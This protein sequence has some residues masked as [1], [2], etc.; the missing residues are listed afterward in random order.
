MAVCHFA[1]QDGT[2]RDRF[3]CQSPNRLGSVPSS[4]SHAYRPAQSIQPRLAHCAVAAYDGGEWHPFDSHFERTQ[5]RTILAPFRAPLRLSLYALIYCWASLRPAAPPTSQAQPLQNQIPNSRSSHP[6]GS[7]ARRLTAESDPDAQPGSDG[8]ERQVRHFCADCHALPDPSAFPKSA[9]M[10]EVRRGYRFYTNSGRTDLT[11]PKLIEVVG[12]FRDR[13][14]D[15]IGLP[16]GAVTQPQSPPRFERQVFEAR[17][18]EAKPAISFLGWVDWDLGKHQVLLSCDMQTGEVGQWLGPQHAEHWHS[19]ARLDHPAHLAPCDLDRD[20]Q[21]DLI[22]ADL[23][24]FAPSDKLKG[25][26]VWLRRTGLEAFEPQTLADGLGRVADVEPGDFDGDGL[27]DLIVAEFG[28]QTAGRILLLRQISDGPARPR[29]E[30]REIDPR[31]GSIHVAPCDLDADGRLDFIALISQEHEVVEAF[32][33]RGA[34]GFERRTLF[35]AGEPSWGSSGVQVVDLDGDGDQ[36]VVCTNGDTFDSFHLKTFHSVAWLENTGQFPFKR[37][38]LANLPGVHR[39][40]SGDLDGDGDLD[41]AACAMIPGRLAR[42]HAALTFDSLIWLE[43]TGPREFTRHTLKQG[44]PNHAA[45]TL[46]D[47]NSDGLLDLAVGEFAE[48]KGAGAVEFWW[49]RGPKSVER[50]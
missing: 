45:L 25:R 38:E 48:V 4:S 21:L 2:P 7:P 33:N 37:H 12:Y 39:A 32:L 14:P 30:P 36:D 35:D 42:R 9:W 5:M 16:R 11:V 40:V 47:F 44:S 49:N 27:I 50:R 26:V 10:D 23:G 41:I 19:L 17:D 22:A 34:D 43:Q 8:L 13:A 24:T 31:H 18:P 1:L 3:Q 29:F 46:G 6:P 20:G 15:H 28:W